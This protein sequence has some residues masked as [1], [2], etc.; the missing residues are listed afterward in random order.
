[1]NDCGGVENLGYLKRPIVVSLIKNLAR[2]VGIDILMRGQCG[3]FV[4]PEDYQ[5]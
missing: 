4:K 2:A 1:M 5:S 3:T